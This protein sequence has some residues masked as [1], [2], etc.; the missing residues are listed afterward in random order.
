MLLKLNC[1]I[2]ER[3]ISDS[4]FIRQRSFSGI[5]PCLLS[6]TSRTLAASYPEPHASAQPFPLHICLYFMLTGTKERTA[7]LEGSMCK[8]MSCLLPCISNFICL[9]WFL[10][11]RGVLIQ[12]SWTTTYKKHLQQGVQRLS[13]QLFY[14]FYWTASFL[15]FKMCSLVKS[16]LQKS[17]G[18][19]LAISK[20]LNS[21]FQTGEWG[22]YSYF[23]TL[24]SSPLIPQQLLMLLSH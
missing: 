2:K 18:F 11:F 1:G 23:F 22:K 19:L 10:P 8:L 4:S 16:A 5:L 17:Q 14:Y 20:S 7:L 21:L 3:G 9:L 13:S 6:P 12:S 15:S 24:F